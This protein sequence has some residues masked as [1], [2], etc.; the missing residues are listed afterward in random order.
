[1][2]RRDEFIERMKAQLDEWNAEIDELAARAR[3][4][5]AETQTRYREDIERL[6]RRRDETRQRLEALQ[7]AS[8]AAWESLREGLDDA[9]ELMRK[10]LRD[11]YAHAP[12]RNADDDEPTRRSPGGSP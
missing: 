8:E 7:F 11:A 4:A 2:N 3:R 1:M 12:D 5:G 9:W 6:K 10:A